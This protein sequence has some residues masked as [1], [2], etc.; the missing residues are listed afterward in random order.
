M[1][2]IES[3]LPTSVPI[4]IFLFS[5]IFAHILLPHFIWHQSPLP[6]PF[7]LPHPS[8]LT[9]II[10]LIFSTSRLETT[11]DV[12]VSY[13]SLSI[14]PHSG[15][16]QSPLPHPYFLPNPSYLTQIIELIFITL[17]LPKSIDLFELIS[18]YLTLF[19]INPHYLT[20]I[21]N[22]IRVTAPK[23]SNSFLVPCA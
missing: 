5:S 11:I 16:H 6:H 8:Y 2:S 17:R 21:L 18:C 15:W 4:R 10:E 13:F 20:H 22:C 1:V 14:L 9:Q 12:E 3:P 19:Y 7:F 23:W